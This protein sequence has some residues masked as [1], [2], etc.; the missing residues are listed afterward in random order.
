MEDQKLLNNV[1]LRENRSCIR[2]ERNILF[3]EDLRAKG[4][5]GNLNVYVVP[6]MPF[7][8]RHEA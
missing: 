4:K 5:N 2:G 8:Y 7:A 1:D 6:L 3:L